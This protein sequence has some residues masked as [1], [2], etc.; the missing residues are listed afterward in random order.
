MQKLLIEKYG[1]C[2]LY[3]TDTNSVSYNVGDDIEVRSIFF[4]E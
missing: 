1:N 2:L 4:A 3:D